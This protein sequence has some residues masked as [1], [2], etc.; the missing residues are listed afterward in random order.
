MFKKTLHC[1]N[2]CI[3]SYF[4]NTVLKVF[5][6]H[7]SP[8]RDIVLQLSCTGWTFKKKKERKFGGFSDV[9]HWTQ[10]P[11]SV[12]CRWV[13]DGDTKTVWL[14]MKSPGRGMFRFAV[15]LM[16]A[17]HTQWQAVV[18]LEAVIT[19]RADHFK[20]EC[21]LLWQTVNVSVF[22]GPCPRHGE[23][24]EDVH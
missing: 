8:Q 21:T 17:H 16:W 12:W 6:N 15:K 20:S 19:I 13:S 10:Q 2:R 24:K 14:F 4:G 18:L 23:Q 7:F 9:S 22:N 3:N 1:S 11:P 5:A